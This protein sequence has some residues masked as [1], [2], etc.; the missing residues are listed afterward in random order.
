MGKKYTSK[1]KPRLGFII[2]RFQPRHIGHENLIREAAKQVEWLIVLIGSVNVPRSIK[3]PWTYRE[4]ATSMQDWLRNEGLQHKVKIY[5][6]NDYRY[7]NAQW[8]ADVTSIIKLNQARESNSGPFECDFFIPDE[9]VALFGFDKTG[10]DY[11]KWFPQYQ[12]IN[13]ETTFTG[14]ASDV[15]NE[16]LASALANPG[17]Y[18]GPKFPQTVID[19]YK[20]YLEEQKMFVDGWIEKKDGIEIHH[21]PYPYPATLNFNCADTV[22]ECAGHI[23]L[24]QRGKTPG[25]GCWALPGGFRDRKDVEWIDAAY[26]ELREETNVRVPD[27][28]LRTKTVATK[29]YDNIYRSFGLPRNT[30]AVHIR[31]EPDADGSLPRANGADDAALAEW[32]SI[33][34]IMNGLDLYDDHK[35][36]IQDMC[37]VL[38]LPAHKNPRFFN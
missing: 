34:E 18:I 29:L 22:L 2:G 4:R 3:N 14:C 38:P 37:R 7:S 13:I 33:D 20:F 9:E 11:L 36:I 15:R 30:L 26:R 21:K 6:V 32:K 23:L 8:T 5:P 28:V 12:Y 17:E 10:N 1:P 31:I 24:V 35:D 16:L 27:V 25:R 19:D